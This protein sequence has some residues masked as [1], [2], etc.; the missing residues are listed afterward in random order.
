VIYNLREMLERERAGNEDL[1]CENQ[2]LKAELLELEQELNEKTKRI[3]LLTLS[4]NR[5]E[6]HSPTHAGERR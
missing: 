3:K 5:R 1:S 2:D 6:L 4:L